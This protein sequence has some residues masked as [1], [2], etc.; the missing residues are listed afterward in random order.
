MHLQSVLCC[1]G[2]RC[3]CCA[4]MVHRIVLSHNIRVCFCGKCVVCSGVSFP[5][6]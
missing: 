2:G 4:Q 1:F 3:F 5:S 6:L